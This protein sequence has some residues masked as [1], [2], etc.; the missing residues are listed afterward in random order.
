[1][2]IRSLQTTVD[3]TDEPVSLEEAKTFLRVDH[4]D[5][6]ALISSMV[7]A[8][9][10][11]CE[12]FTKRHLVT[13]TVKGYADEWPVGRTLEMPRP[14]SNTTASPIVKYYVEGSTSA[15]TLASSVYWVDNQREPGRIVLRETQTWPDASLRS[16]NAVEVTAVTGYGSASDVPD[17][18]KQAMKLLVGHWYM[19]RE[20]VLT[21][22]VSKNLE[23]TVEALLSPHKVASIA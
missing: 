17:G 6:D 18:V 22:T 1:M 21:G 14:F 7:T 3:P 12:A 4:S 2:M 23:L 10:E 16:A 15:T 8:A 20:A 9:R 19:N 5:E 11:Y 13:R